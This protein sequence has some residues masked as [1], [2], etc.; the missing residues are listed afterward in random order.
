MLVKITCFN[1]FCPLYFTFIWHKLSS[2]Y[3]HKCG[4]TL[5]VSTNKT[6]MLPL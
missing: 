5:T 6:Y 2:Y 3:I 1:V 4:F